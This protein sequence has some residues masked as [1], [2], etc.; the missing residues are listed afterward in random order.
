MTP[1]RWLRPEDEFRAAASRERLQNAG[2]ANDVQGLARALHAV[3]LS[4]RVEAAFLLGLTGDDA[5]R[6]VLAG[7]LADE[8]ARVRVEAALALAR[9]GE[10]DQALPLLHQELAGAFFADAPLRAAR[11]L[12]LLGDPSGYGRVLEALASPLP[13]NRM[14]A[15]AVLPAFVPYAGRSTPDGQTID[16]V[17]ALVRAA[18]DAEPI[19]RRDALTALADLDDARARETLVAAGSDPDPDVRDF[20]RAVGNR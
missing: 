8:S 5:A 20:A 14:E 3:D 9:L 17:E 7:G 13:S 6:G 16:P 1:V 12:A 11:A 2:Y 15:I 4:T 18:G 19:L 10:T